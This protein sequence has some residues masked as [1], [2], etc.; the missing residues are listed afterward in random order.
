MILPTRLS[1]DALEILR[2]F[3]RT[4][5]RAAGEALSIELI[6]QRWKRSL[7]GIE[8]G[9]VELE[10]AELVR[11]IAEHEQCAELTATGERFFARFY[12][13]CGNGPV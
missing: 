7:D 2:L 12:H 11:R 1:E 13:S 4:T 3:I 6:N 8:A 5:S 9:I 10:Q